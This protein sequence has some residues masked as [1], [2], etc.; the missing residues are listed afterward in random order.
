MIADTV[1]IPLGYILMIFFGFITWP[2]FYSTGT[3]YKRWPN[4][5]AKEHCE[6]DLK[7]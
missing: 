4:D 5:I 3:Q 2:P 6:N 7:V 1:F